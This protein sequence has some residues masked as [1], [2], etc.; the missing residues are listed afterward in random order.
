DP[1]FLA[2]GNPHAMPAGLAL[3][4]VEPGA[5]SNGD[6]DL[7]HGAG[8]VAEIGGRRLHVTGADHRRGRRRLGRRRGRGGR[9]GRGA[10]GGGGGPGAPRGGGGGAGGR[11]GGGWRRDR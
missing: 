9:N 11:R 1:A 3:E 4:H 8:G 10:G 7:A 2:V 6:H 5:L